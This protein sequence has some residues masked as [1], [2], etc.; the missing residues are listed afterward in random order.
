MK[1][2]LL[3]ALPRTSKCSD[4]RYKEVASIQTIC[5]KTMRAMVRVEGE[6]LLADITDIYFVEKG[7]KVFRPVV[8]II[9]KKKR[10]KELA[11]IGGS[12]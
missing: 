8:D 4:L 5:L 12:V 2:Y 6:Y 7:S 1:I 3:T 10:R 9:H 11:K